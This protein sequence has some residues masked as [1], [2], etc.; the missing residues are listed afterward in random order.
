MH[1]NVALL[2]YAINDEYLA[3]VDVYDYVNVD[4]RDALHVSV[5][6]ERCIQ[7][8]KLAGG[9]KCTSSTAHRKLF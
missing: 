6:G 9:C 4:A 5:N 2:F 8:S 7:R 3:V 1:T